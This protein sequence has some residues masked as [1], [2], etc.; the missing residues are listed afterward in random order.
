MHFGELITDP[1]VNP[2][3]L[4]ATTWDGD[5]AYDALRVMDDAYWLA[6]RT[7]AARRTHPKLDLRGKPGTPALGLKTV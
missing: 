4:E 2:G 6:P 3:T 7:A 5:A 1:A